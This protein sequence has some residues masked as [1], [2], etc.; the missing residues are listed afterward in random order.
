M[1][2][3]NSSHP[4][5]DCTVVTPLTQGSQSEQS[6]NGS[7]V[8]S[9][10]LLLTLKILTLL[11]ES[12]GDVLPE[13]LRHTEGFTWVPRYDLDLEQLMEMIYSSTMSFIVD[14]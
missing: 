13:N 14:C 2:T 8:G 9:A 10:E 4:A 6:V 12:K 11:F 7:L 5:L 1:N 3:E